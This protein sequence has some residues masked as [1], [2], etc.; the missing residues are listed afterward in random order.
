VQHALTDSWLLW[1]L[2]HLYIAAQLVVVPG[3]LM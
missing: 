1:V 3:A 2:N